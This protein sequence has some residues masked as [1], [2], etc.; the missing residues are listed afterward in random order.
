[1]LSDQIVVQ[2]PDTQCL[3]GL[4]DYQYWV[5]PHWHPASLEPLKDFEVAENDAEE[6]LEK[7]DVVENEGEDDVGQDDEG[8]DV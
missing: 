2:L 7:E 1:M 6:T 3:Y 4:H 8:L 5:C